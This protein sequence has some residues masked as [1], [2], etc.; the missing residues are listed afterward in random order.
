MAEADIVLEHLTKRFGDVIAVNDVSVEVER[1]EFLSVIGPSGCG[2]TTTMRM[3]AGLEVPTSGE[4]YIRGDRVANVPAYKRNV[5]MV[6]QSFALFPH[7]SVLGNTEYG[8][9][10]K[11]VDKGTRRAKALKALQTV[12]LEGLEHRSVDQ[13]SGGQKQRLGLARALAV[14]PAFVLLDEPLG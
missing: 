5:A 13:L 6:F 8:L 14:D 4:I 3:I 9:R 1:G 11:G 10:M 2:K 7:M 12:G